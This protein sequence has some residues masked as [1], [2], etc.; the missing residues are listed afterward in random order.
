MLEPDI[1]L[2]VKT[3]VYVA[4]GFRGYCLLMK[5]LHGG[6]NFKNYKGK[7]EHRTGTYCR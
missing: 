7:F 2:A 4:A 3:I 6:A 1:V 5:M